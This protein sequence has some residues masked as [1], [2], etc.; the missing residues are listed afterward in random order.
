MAC[1]RG[2]ARCN[3]VGREYALATGAMDPSAVKRLVKNATSQKDRLDLQ[4]SEDVLEVIAAESRSL[5]V[6]QRTLGCKEM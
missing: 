3:A 1:S 2:A 4:V 5:Y 6:R